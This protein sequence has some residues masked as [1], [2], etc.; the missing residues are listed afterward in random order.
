[1]LGLFSGV[2]IISDTQNA[3]DI[4]VGGESMVVNKSQNQQSNLKFHE[5]S[6]KAESSERQKGDVFFVL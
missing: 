2:D 3:V 6:R 5:A 4:G 1:M